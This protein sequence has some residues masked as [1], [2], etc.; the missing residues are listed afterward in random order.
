MAQMTLAEF[1][2]LF[3]GTPV[4]RARYEGFLR[5]VAVAIGNSGN[6]ALLP[7]VER[8]ASHASPLVARH[9]RRAL[10]RLSAEPVKTGT[11]LPPRSSLE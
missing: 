9:A 11:S 4:S 2:S 3:H 8:L 10:L 1:R 5:N 7:H 6:R